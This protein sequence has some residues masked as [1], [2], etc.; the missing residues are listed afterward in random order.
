[1]TSRAR[2]LVLGLALLLGAWLWA[3][4][5]KGGDPG[6]DLGRAT[7]AFDQAVMEMGDA[8]LVAGPP[9]DHACL[10]EPTA[11]AIDG[12]AR[13]L[14]VDGFGP[15]MRRGTRPRPTVEVRRVVPF[16]DRRTPLAGWDGTPAI[17]IHLALTRF[18]LAAWTPPGN[19]SPGRT[20]FSV[21]GRVWVSLPG[22]GE[23]RAFF[24]DFTGRHEWSFA[25]REL[26]GAP[27]TPELAAAFLFGRRLLE[28]WR[29]GLV[30]REPR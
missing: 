17:T 14:P 26:E 6:Q 20:D 30:W 11:A 7:R 29:R 22:E 19:D 21:A 4:R 16:P 24:G 27:A 28:T 2:L 12:L 25:A 8:V 1:M 3:T 13:R 18:E 15:A 9:H 10:V 5:V 23:A